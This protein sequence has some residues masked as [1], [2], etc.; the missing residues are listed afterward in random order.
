MPAGISRRFKILKILLVSS[1]SGSRGGGEI[2]L[3]YLGRGLARRGHDV[4]MWI[5][6]HS[7]MDELAARCGE[8]AHVIRA[9]YQNTYDYSTRSLATTFNWQ[10]SKRIANEWRTLKPDVIHVNKQNLED[11][12]DLLRAAEQSAIPS[13]CTIHLTQTARYLGAKLSGVRDWVARRSLAEYRGAIVAVQEARRAELASFLESRAPTH[14]IFNGAPPID[15][16][17]AD[18]VR[19]H[20]RKQLGVKESDFLVIGIGRLVA[21]KRPFLFL[22][23]ARELRRHVPSA[24]FVWVGDGE[25]APEWRDR[26][27]HDGLGDVVSCVGWQRDATPY[28]FAGDLLLHVAEYEGLPLAIVEAM[29]AGLPCAVTRNFASEIPLLDDRSVLFADDTSAL[30]RRLADRAHL[31][32]IAAR[33]RR[34]VDNEFSLDAMVNAYE[35]LYRDA[36]A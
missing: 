14:T 23:K 30:A 7:R 36:A 1:G 11:G 32:A 28:L 29:G 12:L 13:V 3:D 31:A 20:T 16:S 22:D 34:L 6:A 21:Q 9:A 4:V 17:A 19:R 25:L 2:F 26:V 5:P 18:E 24:R 15:C 33:A 8:F 10:V 35:R 27:E